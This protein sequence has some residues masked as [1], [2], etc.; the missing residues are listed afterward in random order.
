MK[1]ALKKSFIEKVVTALVLTIRMHLSFFLV[2]FYNYLYQGCTSEGT[3]SLHWSQ[4][5]CFNFL[6]LGIK[7]L[8]AS[9]CHNMI[10]NLS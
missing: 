6:Q 4:H 5:H 10:L 7:K 8:I 1:S 9:L 2:S 3:D